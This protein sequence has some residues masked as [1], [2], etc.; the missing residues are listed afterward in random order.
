MPLNATTS[1]KTSGHDSLPSKLSRLTRPGFDPSDLIVG[2]NP[3][4]S[5][6]SELF[7][8]D[9]FE[10]LAKEKKES[11]RVELIRKLKF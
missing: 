9:K 5:M 7:T 2:N 6:I 8:Q 11:Q 10:F 4:S 3:K 1:E